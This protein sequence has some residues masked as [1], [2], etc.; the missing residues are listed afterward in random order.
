MITVP[1]SAPPEINH[2]GSHAGSVAL[3]EARD[4]LPPT[5]FFFFGFNFGVFTT[6]LLLAEYAV[7]VSSFMLA[8]VLSRK[9][10]R[11]RLGGSGRVSS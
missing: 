6:N 8:T 9:P 10:S 3:N 2:P 7:A 5:I 4:A 1:Q 11:E